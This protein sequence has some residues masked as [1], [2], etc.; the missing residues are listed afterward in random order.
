MSRATG[1]T[2]LGLIRSLAL[3]KNLKQTENETFLMTKGLPCAAR[4]TLQPG[5][6]EQVLFCT[7]RAIPMSLGHDAGNWYS[8]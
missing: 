2:N 3:Y 5:D 7:Y 6:E 1:R 4:R 8:G